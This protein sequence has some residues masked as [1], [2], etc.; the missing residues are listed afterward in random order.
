MKIQIDPHTLERASERGVSESEIK[1]TILNG[2][3]IQAKYGRLGN[4][5]IFSYNK[6]RHGRH[7]QHKKVEVFFIVKDDTAITVTVYAFY[8]EWEE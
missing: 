3:E 1:D 5:K 4:F 2:K 8:G 7:Y 6:S